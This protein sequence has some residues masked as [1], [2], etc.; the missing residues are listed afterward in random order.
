[1]N[2]Y[3]KLVTV[4]LL[5]ASIFVGRSLSKQEE[6][7][8]IHALI[9]TG[10]NNHD[11]ER[12]SPILKQILE[13]T[14]LFT[15]DIATTPPKG[16]SMETFRPQFSDY[17]VV[18]SDYNGDDWLESTLENF[19][20][21]VRS[22]GGV[23]CYHAANNS[24]PTSKEFNTLAG[25][26]GWRGRD[27]TF[28]P[29]IRWRDGKVIRDKTP[30]VGGSHGPAHEFQIV[31]RN[32]DHPITQGLPEKWMHAT[33][34]LYDR[35]R[36]PAENLTLLA[37]AYS[38]SQHE[39]TGEH[40]PILFT[41]KY[42][43]GRV[44]HTVLG[45]SWKNM[46]RFPAV[47]CAGFITTF[48]RGT[49]WA[50][51]GNVTQDIPFDFPTAIEIRKW[52]NHKPVSVDELLE[53][54]S[55]YQFGQSRE[56]LTELSTLIRFAYRSPEV[57]YDIENRMIEFLETDATLAA[58][59]FICRQLSMIGTENAIP[60]LS[61]MLLDSATSDMSRYALERI[62]SDNVDSALRN[63]L[64]KTNGL[65]KIG[66][67][68]TLGQRQDPGS[69]S[70][71]GNLIYDPNPE[72]AKASVAALGQISD[73]DATAVLTE[74]KDKTSGE[75]RMLVL[76][77][78]LNCADQFM[79]NGESSRAFPIFQQLYTPEEPIQIQTGALRGLVFTRPEKAEDFITDALSKGDPELQSG[80][81]KL[82]NELPESQEIG[83]IVDELPSLSVLGQVQLITALGNRG[84]PAF[85]ETIVSS[86]QSTEQEVR[87][88]AIIAL[89]AIGNGSDIDL[90]VNIA[91][92]DKDI[93]RDVARESLYLLRGSKVD[94][95]I[96][97][98]ISETG[99][100]IKV[101]LIRSVGNRKISATAKLLLG[102]ATD[103]DLSIRVE[104]IKALKIVADQQHLSNLINLL[105]RTQTEKERSELENT[106][107]AI[108]LTIPDQNQ[109]AQSVLNVFPSTTDSE[110]R[111]SL[112][113]VLGKIGD[114]SALPVLKNALKDRNSDVKTA[115]IRA[116]SDWP[117][118][119]PIDELLTIAQ[120]SE[121]S[122][123]RFLSKL[124]LTSPPYSNIQRTL[125]LRGY[126][127][128]IGL[129]RER[130]EK[131]TVAMYKKAMDLAWN[132]NEKKMVLSE[133]SSM[134]SL[135]ALTMAVS[136][137]DNTSLQKEAEV[138]VLRLSFATY[139]DFPQKAKE[140]AEKVIQV[141]ENDELRERAQELLNMIE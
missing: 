110:V 78:Y 5:M 105:M 129:D 114:S 73:P 47:E 6:S 107:I 63:A 89:K 106:V 123:K 44:F 38:D 137:L 60:I 75:L 8:T 133:L 14:G 12:S 29:Y 42:G 43:E 128:L 96:M 79:I 55:S 28:G 102:T 37:T 135:E 17:D 56:V 33:D 54:L 80:A 119:E 35:L 19:L 7:A 90:L 30:G 118:S 27:E 57:L 141:T 87:I 59:Q 45:H 18:V 97:K 115:A 121:T 66:I 67:I 104:S 26:G 116:L 22:G 95:T 32:T 94:E 1:M 48:Q 140:A 15:I 51:T 113:Q 109:R 77:A 24:F 50:A 100:N 112:L 41:I 58:K 61:E 64:P 111:S 76:D 132:D 68:N 120:T 84:D 131:E 117:T 9:V 126:I 34:E 69:V 52:K 16:E 20:N 103:P 74:A 4:I 2:R 36:G 31:L 91:A 23:V 86:T 81:I 108:A 138:A 25:L 92:G 11:W 124:K 139:E 134:A 65:I 83:R 122:I 99:G 72:I 53:K 46:E 136:H 130:P 125:A 98:K 40:E 85:H 71:I 88:A 101:E 62:P 82:V 70:L 39:G 3:V 10:Q 127:R 21:Y 13:Q 93:E 49:E